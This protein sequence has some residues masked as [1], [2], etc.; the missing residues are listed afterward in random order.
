M[1]QIADHGGKD[2]VETAIE[3]MPVFSQE[4]QANNVLSKRIMALKQKD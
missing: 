4:I 1:L 3:R 2:L